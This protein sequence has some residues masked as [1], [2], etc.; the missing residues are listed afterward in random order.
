MLSNPAKFASTNRKKSLAIDSDGGFELSDEEDK[1]KKGA[2]PNES[3]SPDDIKSVSTN[4]TIENVN[5]LMY[6][7]TSVNFD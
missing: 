7:M 5:L 6:D 1:K 2:N 3:N 4:A